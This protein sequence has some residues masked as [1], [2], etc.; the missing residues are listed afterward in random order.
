MP[1]IVR[2]N[3]PTRPPTFASLMVIDPSPPTSS[4]TAT[5]PYVP[6]EPSTPGVNTAAYSGL[7]SI[8]PCV[9]A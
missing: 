8:S 6:L 5:C 4:T 9:L 2:R 3:G 7:V 1:E